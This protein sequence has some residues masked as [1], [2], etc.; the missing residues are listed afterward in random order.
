MVEI[1]IKKDIG[2]ESLTRELQKSRK[3]VELVSGLPVKSAFYISL[4]NLLIND[5]KPELLDS[6]N[7]FLQESNSILF[8]MRGDLDKPT[9]FPNVIGN[10]VL[11]E[12]VS[13]LST[14]TVLIAPGTTVHGYNKPMKP[15]V[16]IINKLDTVIASRVIINIDYLDSVNKL[17]KYT[18]SR[19]KLPELNILSLEL[20]FVDNMISVIELNSGFNISGLQV[21]TYS[22]TAPATG[23]TQSSKTA[24][25]CV[26][27]GEYFINS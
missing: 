20:D 8:V 3:Q 4:G 15:S 23:Y 16:D 26:H 21:Y 5:E 2:I 18:E 10:V 24:I 6:V 22:A 12:D 14:G 17:S 19:S 9:S 1:L 27:G 25:Q 13:V 11:L 7:E